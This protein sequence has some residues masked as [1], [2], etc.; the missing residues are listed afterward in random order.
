MLTQ[1]PASIRGCR[2]LEGLLREL[3]RSIYFSF[4]TADGGYVPGGESYLI[5]E[6]KICNRQIYASTVDRPN[7]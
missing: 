4:D 5:L 1:E 2:H 3:F 6:S 7:S